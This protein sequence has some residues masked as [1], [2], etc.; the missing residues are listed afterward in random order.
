ML[1]RIPTRLPAILILLSLIPSA[2]AHDEQPA[3]PA[4]SPPGHAAAATTPTPPPR[5]FASP[6]RAAQHDRLTK[7]LLDTPSPA[8]LRAAHDLLASEPHV[9]NT[10]GGA[11]GAERLASLFRALNLDVELAQYSVLLPRPVSASLDIISPD[12]VSLPLREDPIPE[13]KDSQHPDLTHGWNAWSGSGVATAR[14]VYANYGRKEDFETLRKLGV[15][16]SGKI[17]IARYGGN[18]RGHK[19]RFAQAAGA[20]GLI[21]YTDP[22]DSG[23]AAGLPY[24]EGSFFNDSTIQRG[25]IATLGY[26]G[27]PL[28]PGVGATLDLPDDQRLN[29]ADL[30]LPKI[31]VQPIGYGAAR[32]VLSRFTGPPVHD[33]AWQGALPFTY[34]LTSGDQLAVRLA[35]EQKRERTTI[36]N[37]IA[38]LP[39]ATHPEQSIIIGAHH[40]AW[41]FGADDPLSGTILVVEAARAFAAARDAGLVPQRTIRFAGWDAEEFGIVGSTEWVEHHAVDLAKNCIAY[42]NL[43]AAVSGPRFGAAASPSLQPL[44]RAVTRLVPQPPFTPK[45]N[46]EPLADNAS[47]FDDWIKR[48]PAKFDPNLTAIGTL[49]GGSDHV[50]FVSHLAI[51]AIGMNM[52]GAQGSAYHSNYDNLRWY[53]QMV[54][55]DYLPH[56][57]LT[58]VVALTAAALADADVLPLDPANTLAEAQRHLTTTLAQ[59]PSTSDAAGNLAAGEFAKGKGFPA[60]Q[61]RAADLRAQIDARLASTDNPLSPNQLDAVNRALIDLDRAWLHEQGMPGRPWHRNLF[62][63][64]DEDSGYASWPLPMLRRAVDRQDADAALQARHVYAAHETQ[65]EAR[66]NDLEAA[67]RN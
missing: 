50:A 45:L 42:I 37:V 26:D 52:S 31:P 38:T 15:D 11:R 32:E 10:L 16:C 47:I 6:E 17:V 30:A 48:S 35:V 21:I 1:L 41:N 62:V 24:P 49:G 40:D 61:A 55:D 34:R 23:Y 64:P 3:A 51:P 56:Q 2:L 14:L 36:T 5:L 54:G 4:T 27:D 53:R 60:L 29:E 59:L 44:L 19:A 20:V 46:E 13:D 65:I 39:G 18:F 67:L 66:L 7:V 63:S 25:A 58:R 57:A 33:R 9:A 43:D 12:H 8:S 28:T 22:A